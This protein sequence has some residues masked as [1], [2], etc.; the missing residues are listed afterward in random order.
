M[1]TLHALN[2]SRAT[3]VLWLLADLGKPCDRI[4]YERTKAFRAPEALSRVHPLGKSPVIEDDGMML[5]E[6]A[7]ILRYLVA[8][9]GDHSHTPP[10]GTPAYW[11]H[12]AL[13][14]YVEASLAEVALQAILPA[15]QGQPVP[16]P[17]KTALDTHLDYLTQAIGDGPLLFGKRAMLADIQ[18]SYIVALLARMDL[19]GDHPTVAAYWEA[20]QEQP[21][22]ISAT[23]AAGPMAPPA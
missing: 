3:R 6:S 19:L 11:R 10:P 1:I 20:L 23:Q 15:F 16:E 13:F 8:K 7:T 2:Y 12:E 18:L 21:G 14:D 4:D 5:A 9:Y 17:A 22:Y